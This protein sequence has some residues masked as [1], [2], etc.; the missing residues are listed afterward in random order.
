MD[1]LAAAWIFVHQFKEC[2]VIGCKHGKPP[3]DISNQHVVIVDF[4]FP[5]EQLI[6]LTTKNKSV[7]VLDHHK[8]AE[9]DLI[10]LNIS[11]ITTIFDMSRSG[12]QL[13]YDYIYGEGLNRPC[14]LDIIADRDLWTW[15]IPETFSKGYNS[16]EK[17]EELYNANETLKNELLLRGQRN[18]KQTKNNRKYCKKCIKCYYD[19]LPSD[20]NESKYKTIP[21]SSIGFQNRK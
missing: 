14:F 11:N 4:S 17:M 19:F 9:R 1:G 21:S 16:L 15:R 6:V 8:S 12:C 20:N 13:A 5:R 2:P 3:P 7:I 18:W 10:D